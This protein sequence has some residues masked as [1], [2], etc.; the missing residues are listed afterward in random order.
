MV[1]GLFWL[2]FKELG[3]F[4]KCSGHP[5]N[6]NF[7]ESGQKNTLEIVF[8]TKDQSCKHFTVVNYGC[9]KIKLL[10]RPTHTALE[11]HEMANL[12]QFAATVH[13]IS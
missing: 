8:K 9:K 2:L 3:E 1:F 11:M 13:Y 4:Q 7:Y 12:A 6:N 5:V 10:Q